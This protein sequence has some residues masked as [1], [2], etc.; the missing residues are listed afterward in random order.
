M[1]AQDNLSPQQF[2]H[3][4][5]H[6]FAPGEVVSPAAARG[7]Q[8]NWNATDPSF[9]YATT[10]KLYAHGL[11]QQQAQARGTSG[12]VF[13]VAPLEST[14]PDP[15]DNVAHA[16]RSRQGFRVTRAVPFHEITEA[17]EQRQSV[18]RARISAG[19]KRAQ[20]TPHRFS[21]LG[22]YGCGDCHMPRDASIHR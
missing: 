6:V 20:G 15:I 11:A 17:Q 2:F 12:H 21:D 10:D 16:Y 1:S 18:L 19:V 9:A 4:T 5:T 3:G 8:G 14:E 22:E 13:E 7:V